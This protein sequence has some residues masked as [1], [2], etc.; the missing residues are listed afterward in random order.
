ME[1]I[2]KCEKQEEAKEEGR[3]E[4]K[5]GQATINRNLV[6]S[7]QVLQRVVNKGSKALKIEVNEVN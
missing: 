4:R 7:V 2:L 3:H 5:H 6:G 1:V